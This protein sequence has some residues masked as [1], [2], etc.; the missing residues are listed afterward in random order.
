M[1][2]RL[3]IALAIGIDV[4]RITVSTV[5]DSAAWPEHT[6]ALF[7]RVSGKG[8]TALRPLQRGVS[9]LNAVAESLIALAD[10][11]L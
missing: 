5:F 6:T 11:A 10:Q 3:G 1:L 9:L 8:I 4:E 7:Q 2:G